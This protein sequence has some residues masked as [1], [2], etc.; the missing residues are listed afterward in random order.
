MRIDPEMVDRNSPIIPDTDNTGHLLRGR[1]VFKLSMADFH[2]SVADIRF[3]IGQFNKKVQLALDKRYAKKGLYG[4]NVP[5]EL[6]S[7]LRSKI[8]LLPEKTGLR[9]TAKPLLKSRG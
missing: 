7:S 3:V 6:T 9:P 1:Y 5:K 2:L 8:L 4:E